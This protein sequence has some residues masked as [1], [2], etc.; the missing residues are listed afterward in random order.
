M[1]VIVA[2]P[3]AAWVLA[4]FRFLSFCFGGDVSLDLQRVAM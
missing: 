3:P 1:T 4:R 2:P